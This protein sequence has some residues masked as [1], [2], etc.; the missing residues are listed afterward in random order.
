MDILSVHKDDLLAVYTLEN[1]LFGEH[2]YP[3]FFF[4]QAFDCWRESF[5]VAKKGHLVVGYILL[6]TSTN[7]QQY[8]IMS[9]AV[10]TPY[11]GKGIARELIDCVIAPLKLGSSV[12]LTVDP[13]NYPALSLYFSLGF[14][15]VEEE[16][17]YFG[18][19]AS[20]LVMELVK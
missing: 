1:T 8:W 11:R 12:K 16:S 4:R 15:V 19:K 18:D 10:D 20:R 13:N 7:A 9:L 2:A 3:Q 14:K 17:H 5:L 6:T